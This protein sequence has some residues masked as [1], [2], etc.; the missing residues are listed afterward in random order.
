MGVLV[1]VL[2]SRVAAATCLYW[3]HFAGGGLRAGEWGDDFP[4]EN[5]PH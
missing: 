5:T 3:L 4:L 2:V 1:L